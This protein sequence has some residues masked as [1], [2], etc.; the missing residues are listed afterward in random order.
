LH[1]SIIRLAR[2]W[3]IRGLSVA[4]RAGYKLTAMLPFVLY[5]AAGALTAVHVYV[6]LSLGILGAPSSILEFVAL[7][8]SLGLIA[9]GYVSL[10]RSQLAAR[11]ALIA[12]LG[13]W[14]F[15]AP[16]TVATVKAGRHSQ[17]LAF[18]TSVLPL[19]AVIFLVLAT[20]SAALISFKANTSGEDGSWCLPGRASR[21][22]RVVVGVCSVAVLFGFAAWLTFGVPNS[23]RP[24]SWFVIPD[25]YVGWVRVQ[26][27]VPGAPSTPIEREHYIFNIPA[28]GVLQT[29]S[30][31]SFGWSKDEYFYDSASGL[32]DLRA[33]G[34]NG[35]MVWGQV[36]GEHGGSS[37]TQP[38]QEFF[39]GTEQ[40]FRALAGEKGVSPKAKAVPH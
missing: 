10:F 36:N 34:T 11:L 38:Y 15:Y 4:E 26:F 5:V 18:R 30:P 27:Q 28:G 8:A 12:A 16:A 39:V 13:S 35:R 17:V 23:K 20:A 33:D 31:E 22:L 6:L 1:A 37:G 2:T 25:G 24:P 40:Q 29:S 19:L 3:D 32:H 7:L 14:C 21:S 9:A